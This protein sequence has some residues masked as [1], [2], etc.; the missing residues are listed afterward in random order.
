MSSSQALIATGDVKGVTSDWL[1]LG[2]SAAGPAA[3][4]GFVV[5]RRWTS[6][7]RAL[8]GSAGLLCKPSSGANAL[9]FWADLLVRNGSGPAVSLYGEC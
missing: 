2:A 6:A 5:L 9:E 4:Q 7:S 3:W 1:V 8:L